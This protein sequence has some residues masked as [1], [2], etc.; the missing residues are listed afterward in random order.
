MIDGKEYMKVKGSDGHMHWQHT[1]ANGT[2]LRV[3]ASGVSPS[4]EVGA[5]GKPGKPPQPPKEGLNL[6]FVNDGSQ[7]LPNGGGAFQEP[8][9]NTVGSGSQQSAGSPG[10]GSPGSPGTPATERRERPQPARWGQRAPEEDD[11]RRSWILGGA[12]GLGLRDDEWLVRFVE[13]IRGADR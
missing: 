9:M 1:K 8:S 5:P 2:R 6:T 12:P 7:S 4:A 10:S 11:G 13:A 3:K